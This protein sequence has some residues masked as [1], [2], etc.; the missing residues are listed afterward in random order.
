MGSTA[1]ALPKTSSFTRDFTRLRGAFYNTVL[2]Y[3]PITWR[4]HREA[5][6]LADGWSTCFIDGPVHR[7]WQLRSGF[8]DHLQSCEMTKSNPVRCALRRAAAA[9]RVQSTTALAAAL[10]AKTGADAA[11]RVPNTLRR[12]CGCSAACA[13]ALKIVYTMSEHITHAG[14]AP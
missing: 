12:A 8:W 4:G 13:A 2:A 6:L 11:V 14:R 10:S 7:G 9:G 5:V 1:G 3:K